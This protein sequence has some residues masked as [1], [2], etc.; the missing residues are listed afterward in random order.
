[1]KKLDNLLTSIAL[2][3]MLALLTTVFIKL[4]TGLTIDCKDELVI[5]YFICQAISVYYILQ[6]LNLSL[7]SEI[8]IK[9]F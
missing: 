7:L 5:V 9:W 4:T 3:L 8:V 6:K 1:M 2:T